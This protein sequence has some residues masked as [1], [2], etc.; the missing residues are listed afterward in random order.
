MRSGFIGARYLIGVLLSCPGSLAYGILDTRGEVLPCSWLSLYVFQMQTA[1]ASP[2]VDQLTWYEVLLQL[3]QQLRQTL[4][5]RW[6]STAGQ[7]QGH[8]SPDAT[9]A[10]DPKSARPREWRQQCTITTIATNSQSYHFHFRLIR[11][12]IVWSLLCVLL[13]RSPLVQIPRV[14]VLPW[15]CWVVPLHREW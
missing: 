10:I 14:S 5:G 2:C 11:E 6:Q 9:L 4:T 13:C 7:R 8:E 15:C 1:R 12:S 3:T